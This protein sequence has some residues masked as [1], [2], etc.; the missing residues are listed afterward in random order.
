[1]LR[2][3]DLFEIDLGID[4]VFRGKQN[5]SD[6]KVRNEYDEK[7]LSSLLSLPPDKTSQILKTLHHVG[8]FI[9]ILYFR[10]DLFDLNC[11]TDLLTLIATQFDELSLV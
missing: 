1:M 10:N 9:Q 8:T 7:D 6:G 4:V 11:Q 3:L 2:S 5:I